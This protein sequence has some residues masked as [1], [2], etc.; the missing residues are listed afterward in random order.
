MARGLSPPLSWVNPDNVTPMD[1]L[2]QLII[3]GRWCPYCNCETMLVAGHVIYA[4]WAQQPERPKFLNKQYHRCT[5]NPNHYVGTYGDNITSL[6]RVADEELR[7]LKQ[8]GHAAF[9]PMWKEKTHFKRQKDAYRWLSGK[10]NLPFSLTHFG[11]F[12]AVQCREAIQ[13][14]LE[15]RGKEQTD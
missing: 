12:D 8:E 6:G 10:M 2:H 13:F 3:T 7:R 11:M 4:H 1:A 15:H 5:T 9:D 14:S